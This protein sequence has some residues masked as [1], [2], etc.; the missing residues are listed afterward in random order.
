M[1]KIFNKISKIVSK[2]RKITFLFF[3]FLTF[4]SSFVDA[5]SIGLI[6]PFIGLFLDYNKTI[7]V[8][9]K[10]NFLDLPLEEPA[11]YFLI[12]TIFVSAI[13]FSTI[14]KIFQS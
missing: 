9:S 10:F 4:T 5:V 12:T 7:T 8:L 1:L 13:I 3:I 14:F 2:K 11:I 6:I